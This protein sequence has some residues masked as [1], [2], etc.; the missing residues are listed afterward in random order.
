MA[1]RARSRNGRTMPVRSRGDSP[2]RDIPGSSIAFRKRCPRVALV[3]PQ[4][5]IG[6]TVTLLCSFC[7]MTSAVLLSQP[8]FLRSVSTISLATPA[9]GAGP[10]DDEQPSRGDVYVP[11]RRDEIDL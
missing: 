11:I 8:A 1:S 5:A 9:S 6:L 4:P 3:G 7:S 2:R 10:H